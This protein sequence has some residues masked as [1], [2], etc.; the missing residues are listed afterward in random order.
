MG[1]LIAGVYIPQLLV[2]QT[3]IDLPYKEDIISGWYPCLTE[4]ALAYRSGMFPL[5]DTQNLFGSPLIAYS[6][7]GGLYPLQMF[8]MIAFKYGTAIPLSIFLH[9]WLAAGLMYGFLRRRGLSPLAGFLPALCYPLSGLFFFTINHPANLIV[10]TWMPL[11]YWITHIILERP[12]LRPMLLL[13]LV[14]CICALAGEVEAY[15]YSMIGLFL[16][17]IFCAKFDRAFRLRSAGAILSASILAGLMIMPFFLAIQEML[18]FSI[19]GPASEF[20]LHY[21]CFY[22]DKPYLMIPLFFLPFKYMKDLFPFDAFNNGLSPIYL[23]LAPLLAALISIRAWRRDAEITTLHRWLITLLSIGLVFYLGW[24]DGLLKLIPVIGSMANRFKWVE[25]IAFALLVL[26]G[27]GIDSLRNEMKHRI[28]ITAIALALILAAATASSAPWCS[29]GWLRLIP[30]AILL[31]SGLGLA[32]LRLR[33]QPL[34]PKIFA[35]GLALVLIADVYLLAEISVPR[36]SPEIFKAPENISDAVRP[37]LP[38]GLFRFMTLEGANHMDLSPEITGFLQAET[39]ADSLST[40]TRLPLYRSFKLLHEAY[41]GIVARSDS[42]SLNFSGLS[43]LEPEFLSPKTLQLFNLTGVRYVISR[44]YSLKFSSPYYL[45][46]PGALPGPVLFRGRVRIEKQNGFDSIKELQMNFSS[47][48]RMSIMTYPD[49][50]LAWACRIRGPGKGFIQTTAKLSAGG[51]PSL[52]FARYADGNTAASCNGSLFQ[53]DRQLSP[54]GEYGYT[55]NALPVSEAPGGLALIEPRI[56][57]KDAALQETSPGS[58]IYLNQYALPRAFVV[59]K[60]EL[61][62]GDS[63]LIS[64]LLNPSVFQPRTS[65][66]LSNPDPTYNLINSPGRWGRMPANEPVE[67]TEYSAVR[68]RMRVR[69]YAPGYLVMT[70]NY[71]PGWRVWVNGEEWKILRGDYAFR[72]VFLDQGENELEFR[73]V[74]VCFRLGLWVMLSSLA[75]MVLIAVAGFKRG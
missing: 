19:R 51:Q 55:I 61:I 31:V 16:F 57:R 47:S 37:R 72:A 45:L 6:Y 9:S 7:T 40:F 44:R 4:T 13:A 10:M 17:I 23:G 39:R 32:I 66:L 50:R 20:K 73:Y 1:L 25:V 63:D 65:V 18:H 2:G 22:G 46:K 70:D 58:G 21:G 35:S 29:G 5:W 42:G 38:A 49:S 43:M 62:T 48:V 69:M 52:L 30:A 36:N 11:I 12:K 15:A 34:N 33:G 41:S 67:V 75:A 8:F 71:Y 27:H 74:P 14:M 26:A 64:K 28:P 68:A 53:I 60:A 3:I 54:P 24:F 56:I 59:H